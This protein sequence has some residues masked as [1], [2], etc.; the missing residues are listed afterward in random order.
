MTD[1]EGQRA[2]RALALVREALLLL[3]AAIQDESFGDEG[4]ALIPFVVTLRRAVPPLHAAGAESVPPGESP[5]PA[6]LDEAVAGA[7]VLVD[8]AQSS[9][10]ADPPP[11][12]A[13]L[14]AV[15]HLVMGLAQMSRWG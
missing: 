4:L 7:V 14:E 2:T 8:D 10:V 3:D 13:A 6:S 9:F 5:A 12:S 1:A 15:S 11:T